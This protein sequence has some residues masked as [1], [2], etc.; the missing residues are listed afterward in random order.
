MIPPALG[1][2]LC[3]NAAQLDIQPPFN[4]GADFE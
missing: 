4:V 2:T 3:I 1:G